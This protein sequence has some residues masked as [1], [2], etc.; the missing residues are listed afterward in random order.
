MPE[1]A[2]SI[3]P[4]TISQMFE[5]TGGTHPIFNALDANNPNNDLSTVEARRANYS[6]MLT[7]G[8]N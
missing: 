3:N 6:R 2:W 5:L 1:N 7:R 4:A 8:G